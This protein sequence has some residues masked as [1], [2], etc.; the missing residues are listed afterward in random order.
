M[1]KT[2]KIFLILAFV[3]PAIFEG[4]VLGLQTEMDDVIQ[5]AF[6]ILVHKISSTASFGGAVAR[7][8][9]PEKWQ[10]RIGSF[11]TIATFIGI[12]IGMC[13]DSS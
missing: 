10:K 6:G 1:S 11:F 3:V 9:Y 12:V 2:S 4:I 7:S 5:L 8:I 13:L